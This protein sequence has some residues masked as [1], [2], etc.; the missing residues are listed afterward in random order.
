MSVYHVSYAAGSKE[1]IVDIEGQ[2]SFLMEINKKEYHDIFLF[3]K[4]V[5]DNSVYFFMGKDD[6]G[7]W[8]ILSKFTVPSNILALESSLSEKVATA[9]SERVLK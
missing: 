2:K 8:V 9:M 1:F 7:M 4:P 3:C 6:V 5:N